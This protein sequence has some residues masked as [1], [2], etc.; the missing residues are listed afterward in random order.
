MEKTV[1][2]CTVIASRPDAKVMYYIDSLDDSGRSQQYGHTESEEEILK[3]WE[4][5]KVDGYDAH[6]YITLVVDMGE[7][8][9]D[10]I[11]DEVLDSWVVDVDGDFDDAEEEIE[12]VLI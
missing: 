6:L 4:E 5:E 7:N 9:F 10:L 11:D 1:I 8:G 2:G 3:M 12:T